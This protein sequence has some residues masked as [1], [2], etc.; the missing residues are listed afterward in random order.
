MLA[1]GAVFPQRNPS[2]PA[3]TG[4]SIDWT[5]ILDIL[6]QEESAA[7]PHT[8]TP[9][10]ALTIAAAVAGTAAGSTPY[11]VGM[12]NWLTQ[13][14]MEDAERSNFVTFITDPTMPSVASGWIIQEVADTIQ[15]GAN[16]PQVDAYLSAVD[17]AGNLVSLNYADTN[18]QG[19]TAT[20]EANVTTIL[21][22]LQVSTATL[23]TNVGPQGP[24][25]DI[26]LD[27]EPKGTTTAA[28]WAGMM[29]SVAAL[30]ETH[31]SG[32][33]AAYASLSGFISMA[34]QEDL[35]SEGLIANV[36]TNMD[37]LIVMAYRNLPC[38]SAPCV[39][40]KTA[41]CADGFMKWGLALADA[42][43]PG[44]HCA[45]ALELGMEGGG[46]GGS[47]Y[48]IS[49]GATGIYN[50]PQT[51]DPQTYRRNYLTQAMDEGWG[52]M[53]SAQQQKFHPAGA[54]ILHSYQWLSCFRDGVAATGGG[55]CSPTGACGDTSKCVPKLA[56]QASDLNFDGIV[57]AID[58]AVVHDHLG[59][60]HHDSTL[61]GTID[62]NDLLT[63]ISQWGPCN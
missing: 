2:I 37:T 20:V 47:C 7:M 50:H 56:S 33:P 16:Y 48:K 30:I 63:L 61:D 54:F 28:E 52:M 57:N 12:M 46:I 39:G 14:I 10:F 23:T 9:L 43:P 29:S 27:V 22:Y 40:T 19:D 31:N 60:C 13:P 62:I 8:S 24:T 35:I 6:D 55:A 58:L 4:V 17:A 3:F 42:T 41:P 45:I 59:T 53:S 26:N 25:I 21:D 5:R 51:A 32:S 49:F 18:W 1:R 11:G 36:W 15:G 44:K 38:F 34:V